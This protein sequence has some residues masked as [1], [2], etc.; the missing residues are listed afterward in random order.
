[1]STNILSDF[2]FIVLKS[3]REIYHNQEKSSLRRVLDFRV[4]STKA[5]ALDNSTTK[6]NRRE[7]DNL[8]LDVHLNLDFVE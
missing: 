3:A 1:M 7:I 5:T 8:E 4:Q 6:T 2:L